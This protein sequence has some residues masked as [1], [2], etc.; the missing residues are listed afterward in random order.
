MLILNIAQVIQE[1]LSVVFLY[2]MTV[3]LFSEITSFI[4]IIWSHVWLR[5]FPL[6]RSTS[7][8]T[9]CINPFVD[10]NQDGVRLCD[11]TFHFQNRSCV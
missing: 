7:L 10:S 2:H 3:M 6:A 5:G 1:Y 8:I 11:A 4:K 9:I